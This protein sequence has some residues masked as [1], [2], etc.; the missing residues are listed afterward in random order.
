MILTWLWKMFQWF[1]QSRET[2]AL[3][4]PKGPPAPLG[5]ARADFIKDS[6]DRNNSHVV[7][8]EGEG[9]AAPPAN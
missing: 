5:E 4:A 7:I 9:T 2:P 6:N 1:R 8:F 3:E